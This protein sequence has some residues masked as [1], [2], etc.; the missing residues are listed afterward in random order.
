MGLYRR[1]STR[2]ILLVLPESAEGKIENEQM[3]RPGFPKQ[4]ICLQELLVALAGRACYCGETRLKI[5]CA[6]PIRALDHA[7]SSVQG[8]VSV[9]PGAPGAPASPP[10]PG[11]PAGPG[12]PGV[13]GASCTGA[14][15]IML[16][17]WGPPM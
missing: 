9:E 17:T 15:C 10:A 3:A 2:S 14:R 5:L 1:V 16:M 4:A 11:A 6:N 13:P 7:P 8:V 12:M